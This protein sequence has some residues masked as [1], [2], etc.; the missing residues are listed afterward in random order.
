MSDNGGQAFRGAHLVFANLIENYT[1]VN[2]TRI[3]NKPL[4]FADNPQ[5]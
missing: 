1:F 4:I 3:G 5:C 2:A